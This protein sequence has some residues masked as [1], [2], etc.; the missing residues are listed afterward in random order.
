M[1]YLL[2]TNS[3]IRHL[4]RRSEQLTIRLLSVPEANIALC[5][6]VKAELYTGALKSQNPQSTLAKQQAFTERFVSLAF[7]DE[8]AQEYARIRAA[9][10][11]AGTP[12]GGNDMMIAAIA[13]INSLTLVTHNTREFGRIKNLP[14]EDWEVP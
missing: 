1:K 10:E 4:N 13:R 11:M 14:L 12:I 2:D 3:C 6:I 7:N 9:L 8:A 5:S